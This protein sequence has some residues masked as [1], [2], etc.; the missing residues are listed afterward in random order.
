M[1]R[2]SPLVVRKVG[3]Y[4]PALAGARDRTQANLAVNDLRLF[5]TGWA[6]GLIFFVTFLG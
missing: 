6:G 3:R 2:L 1:N 4:A 5:L